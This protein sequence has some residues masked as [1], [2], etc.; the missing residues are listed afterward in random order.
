ME[1]ELHGVVAVTAV[2]Y[3]SEGKGVLDLQV[4]NA[5]SS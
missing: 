2:V 3:S 4:I 1:E 5:K